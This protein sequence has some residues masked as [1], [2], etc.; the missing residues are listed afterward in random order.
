MLDVE[1]YL[2]SNYF[3]FTLLGVNLDRSFEY[4]PIRWFMLGTA[5]LVEPFGNATAV[6]ILNFPNS[7]AWNEL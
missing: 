1:L 6:N 5:M 4:S 2:V 7:I 3:S